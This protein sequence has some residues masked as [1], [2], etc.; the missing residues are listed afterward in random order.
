MG[1]ADRSLCGSKPPA[2]VHS[3]LR[4]LRMRNRR[5]C[6]HRVS[7]RL[8]QGGVSGVRG[9]TAHTIEQAQTATLVREAAMPALV[10]L[11]RRL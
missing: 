4:A 10:S 8:D 3:P 9:G 1:E 11:V 2:T 7:H 5:Y 6:S